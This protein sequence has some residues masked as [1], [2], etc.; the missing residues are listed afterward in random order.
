MKKEGFTAGAGAVSLV[1]IFSVLCLSV[2]AVLTLSTASSESRTTEK[3]AQAT[4][5]YYNADIRAT[6]IMASLMTSYTE[7]GSVPDNVGDVSIDVQREGGR[8]SASYSCMQSDTQILFIRLVFEESGV[9]ILSW[10]TVMIADWTAETELDIWQP[11]T[12]NG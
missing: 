2:L 8:T 5:E 1:L 9:E 12:G 4:T 7:D 11:D 6:E 10:K 3:I